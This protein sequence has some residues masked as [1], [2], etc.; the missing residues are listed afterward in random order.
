MKFIAKL[1]NEDYRPEC[2]IRIGMSSGSS[3][4][5][6]NWPDILPIYSLYEQFNPLYFLHDVLDEDWTWIGSLPSDGKSFWSETNF[7][8]IS[9]NVHKNRK[10]TRGENEDLVQMG[11]ITECYFLISSNGDKLVIRLDST[12]FEYSDDD[13]Y[14]LLMGYSGSQKQL[15]QDM[16]ELG[17]KSSLVNKV[18]LNEFS[19]R[20][21]PWIQEDY[22]AH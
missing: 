18:Y 2:I 15:Q 16:H 11:K 14:T 1:K 5:E 17:I 22:Y 6:L 8:G 4:L 19:S 10:T 7:W 12:I 9:P 21:N 3:H 13:K 20:K